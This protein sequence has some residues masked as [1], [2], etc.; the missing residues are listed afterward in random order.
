M[1][2]GLLPALLLLCA[3]SLLH[4]AG[5][6]PDQVFGRLPFAKWKTEGKQ[7]QIRWT[8][9]N[10][11]PTLSAHQR[12]LLRT[13][14]RIDGRELEKRRADTSFLAL[15]EYRDAAG[16][17][18]QNHE[19]IDPSKLADGIVRQYLDVSFYAF[20]LPGQYTVSTAICDPETLQHSVSVRRVRAEPLRS[21]PLPALWKNMPPVEIIPPVAEPPDVWYLPDMVTRPT[22]KVATSHPVRLHI[23]LNTTPSQRSSGSLTALRANMSLL[24][25]ALKVL[26]GIEFPNGSIDAEMLD[27]T[28][29]KVVFDQKTVHALTWPAMRKFFVDMRPG[30][31]DAA[32]LQ[33]E[34]KMRRFFWDEVTR[35]LG[36]ERDGAT[37][38]VLVLSGP[39]FL[40]DQEPAESAPVEQGKGRIFY[41]RYR[42]QT[43]PSR[44]FRSSPLRDTMVGRSGR[45][46]MMAPP[47]SPDYLPPMPLDDLERTLQPLNARLFDAASAQ[48]FRRVLAAVLEQISRI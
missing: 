36:P 37:P 17:V 27:L 2:R 21:D 5:G 14:V 20:L 25:P 46:R 41:I 30:V 34:W 7:S 26:S 33:G 28:H 18:W 16:D 4:A 19:D 47:I 22:L 44:A 40:E 12:L 13:V 23:L 32:T 38:V 48:Q 39:A 31:I 35:N 1:A 3:T 6:S 8:L 24:I 10:P 45:G 43:L 29:R 42:A 9:F 15:I 11:E